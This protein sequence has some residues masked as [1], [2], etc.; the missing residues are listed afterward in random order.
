VENHNFEVKNTNSNGFTAKY[1][2][3]PFFIVLKIK[4]NP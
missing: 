2:T 1:Y 4:L 3:V